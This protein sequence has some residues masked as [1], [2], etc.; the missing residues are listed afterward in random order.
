MFD[1][2]LQLYKQ[3]APWPTVFRHKK[4]KFILHL[5]SISYLRGKEIFLLLD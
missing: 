5:T 2:L 4:Y 3:P 1:E